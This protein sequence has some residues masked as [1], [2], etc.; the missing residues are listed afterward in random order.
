MPWGEFCWPSRGKF[1]NKGVG[2]RHI[3]IS[4]FEKKSMGII[5]NVY[6]DR[7]VNGDLKVFRL[8]TSSG[9]YDIPCSWWA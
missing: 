9:A 1:V 2:A 6:N 3:V 8:D 5:V 4:S 7:V